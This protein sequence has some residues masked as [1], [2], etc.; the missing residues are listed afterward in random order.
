VTTLFNITITVLV[1]ILFLT[2]IYNSIL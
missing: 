2:C 1:I